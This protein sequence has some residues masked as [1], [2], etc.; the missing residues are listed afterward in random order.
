MIEGQTILCF[1]SGYDAPPTSKHHVMH[2]LTE[3]NVV[4]WVNYHASRAPTASSSDVAYM[5]RKLAQVFAG[6]KSPRENLHVLTPL[7][8]PLPEPGFCGLPQRFTAG[9]G[10]RTER[11]SH[12]VHD[13]P[14]S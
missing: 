9:R 14:K 5:A 8:V 3:R 10:D 1:A 7:V 13:C 11:R 2:I 6:M 12:A 4:L